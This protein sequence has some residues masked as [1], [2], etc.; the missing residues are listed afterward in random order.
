MAARHLAAN[1]YVGRLKG[2]P[3]FESTE[4]SDAY[5][6]IANREI[7]HHRVFQPMILK[8]PYPSYSSNKLLASEQYY[9]EEINGSA[10]PVP[11]KAA[12]VKIT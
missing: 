2:L 1:G 11:E 5:I 7:V 12:T 4:H 3:V 8:G 6:V 10:A 9:A